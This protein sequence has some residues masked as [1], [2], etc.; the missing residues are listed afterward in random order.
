MNVFTPKHHQWKATFGYE[1]IDAYP[2][3][4][5]P[6]TSQ[7]IRPCY[8][9]DHMTTAPLIFPNICTGFNQNP[10]Y[11]ARTALATRHSAEKRLQNHQSLVE[12]VSKNLENS[13]PV[14]ENLDN[15]LKEQREALKEKEG[16]NC[17]LDQ[18]AKCLK[19]RLE[20]L[21]SELKDLIA[22]NSR[23]QDCKRELQAFIR[24]IT[25]PLQIAQE[26]LNLRE[27]RS[28]NELVHDQV[29]QMLLAEAE[30][31]REHKRALGLLLEQCD[32]Q[33]LQGRKI[34]NELEN[35]I[36]T[37]Q[38]IVVIE[39]SKEGIERF[40]GSQSNVEKFQ[41]YFEHNQKFM[42]NS[43]HFRDQIDANMKEA[44]RDISRI[45]LKTNK[46]FEEHVTQ[47]LQAKEE[48]QNYLVQV[49]DEIFNLERNLKYLKPKEHTRLA[50][51]QGEEQ[52]K[53]LLRTKNNL[54]SILSS[55]TNS[56]VIDSDKCMSMRRCVPISIITGGLC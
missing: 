45:W 19:T 15:L 7:S 27:S 30:T 43:K 41:C 18:D 25:V 20:S 21:T 47:L 1:T 3:L 34:Q 37:V 42:E 36:K 23:L 48:I 50:L 38:W 17:E 52:L 29:E 49:K 40:L 51:Q 24:N 55:T 46:C 12:E 54:Q 32:N 31:Y 28:K 53:L 13:K 16:G 11:V 8:A 44:A 9:P 5:H 6:V 22:E 39:K 14:I 33:Q 35:F 4:S 2:V 10:I 26:C 56:L